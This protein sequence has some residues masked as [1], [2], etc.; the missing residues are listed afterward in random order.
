M[1]HRGDSDLPPAAPEARSVP[2]W[3]PVIARS[4]LLVRVASSN[5]RSRTKGSGGPRAPLLLSWGAMPAR[6]RWKIDSA[7]EFRARRGRRGGLGEE[8]WGGW[9]GR[10]GGRLPAPAGHA[11]VLAQG[12][13]VEVAR[14]DGHRRDACGGRR[15]REGPG[16][17][18][19]RRL[20]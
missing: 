4:S 20:G 2:L 15:A 16:P 3:R 8:R 1:R 13:G 17:M 10:G 9:G 6:P 5:F 7:I 12:A 14:D 11:P 18:K 19:G